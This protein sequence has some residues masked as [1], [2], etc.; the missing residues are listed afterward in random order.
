MTGIGDHS[1]FGSADKRIINYIGLSPREQMLL[2]MADRLEM[3]AKSYPNDF[4][5]LDKGKDILNVAVRNDGRNSLRANI[6][7]SI[8]VELNWLANG[9]TQAD[10]L[11]PDVIIAPNPDG[12]A[13]SGSDSEDKAEIYA[14]Y[15][16]LITESDPNIINPL[17]RKLKTDQ[18]LRDW[19]FGEGG[20]VF[21][22]NKYRNYAKSDIA[23]Q[24]RILISFN[25]H[26]EESAHQMLYNFMSNAQAN[27]SGVAGTKSLFHKTA[28][29]SLARIAKLDRTLFSALLETGIMRV[30][31]Q[32]EITP[33]SGFDTIEIIKAVGERPPDQPGIG[34]VVT[35][36]TI[37]AIGKLIVI[38]AGAV[39]ATTSLINALKGQD[40]LAVFNDSLDRIQSGS[41]SPST[42]DWIP[43]ASTNDGT[44][45]PT[46]PVEGGLLGFDN[47]TLL[48]AGGV[49]AAAYFLTQ[50]K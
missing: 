34:I 42:D 36:A 18:E 35:A 48:I 29:D 43:G 27:A 11:S 3:Y 15:Q 33:L 17:I 24:I 31:T 45:S 37:T 21:N 2:T 32:R 23:Q 9:I 40:D 1:D 41:A 38:I 4:E 13:I 6:T 10:L 28:V 16:T 26:L 49:A 19:I 50:R 44:G 22:N 30:N 5:S 8:P 20:T 39:K 25:D 7:G 47:Q 14:A 12:P 46:V